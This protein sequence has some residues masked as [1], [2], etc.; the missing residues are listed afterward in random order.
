MNRENH[1]PPAR[2]A[3]PESIEKQFVHCK[4]GDSYPANSYG[5]G[6]IEAN[7]GVCE[8]CDMYEQR[9]SI[10]AKAGQRLAKAA[11]RL[12]VAEYAINEA[13]KG[14]DD[15]EVSAC[16]RALTDARHEFQASAAEVSQELIASGHHMAEG[17]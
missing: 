14:R 1:T 3:P 15:E 2:T 6:F 11:H 4:C 5:A 16:N 10:S 13:I 17:D 12:Q 9:I 7:G 8:N